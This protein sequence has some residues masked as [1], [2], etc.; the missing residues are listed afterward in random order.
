MKFNKPDFDLFDYRVVALA[1]DGCLQ[2]RLRAWLH[3]NLFRATSGPQNV[4]PQDFSS[5]G[6]PIKGCL[7]ISKGKGLKSP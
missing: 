6:A 2:D 5:I 4:N 1:G 3:E 7:V